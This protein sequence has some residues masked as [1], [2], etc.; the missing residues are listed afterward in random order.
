[1]NNFLSV[2]TI[3]VV[4]TT[5]AGQLAGRYLQ[6]SSNG[7]NRV[8]TVMKNNYYRSANSLPAVSN[9]SGMS[10]SNIEMSDCYNTG[11][12]VGDYYVGGVAGIND[13]TI[14]NCYNAGEVSGYCYVGGV[15]GSNNGTITNCYNTGEASATSSVS[16]VVGYNNGKT[17]NSYYLSD[18]ETDNFD[19]TTAKT[20]DQFASGEVAYLLQGKQTE[21][22]WGQELNKDKFP[23][24]GGEKVY[25]VIPCVDESCYSN[26]ATGNHTVKISPAK[27]ANCTKT[28]LTECK[29]CSRCGKTL[30]ASEIIPAAEHSFENGKCTVCGAEPTYNPNVVYFIPKHWEE[31]DA[32]FAVLAWDAKTG[33]SKFVKLQNENGIYFAEIGE[34]ID[35]VFFRMD[36]E[37]T[38][39]DLDSVWNQ[40][41]VLTIPKGYNCFTVND[42]EYDN[43]NGIW[44]EYLPVKD[45]SVTGDIN[46]TLEEINDNIYTGVV[47][48]QVGTYSFN[49]NDDGTTLGF[50]GTYTDTATIDYSAG[51]TE[52]TKLNA[53]GGKYTFTYNASTKELEIE[54]EPVLVFG[55]A[56][57]NGY[58][59]IID[60]IFVLE[61]IVGK[62]ALN[63]VQSLC[64]DVDSNG[65]ISVLD[66]VLIQKM[67]LGIV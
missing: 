15:A 33:D 19:D 30:V 59:E 23:V 53:T 34:Y 62:I 38:A 36:P 51:T 67:L 64:A 4:N 24:L 47:E 60:V 29:K 41:D 10:Y 45:I 46:L 43:A 20:A 26:T 31:A 37:K 63:E 5:F 16:G 58:I 13:G 22:I 8:D 14:T 39:V 18:S 35:M 57:G 50:N 61:Y 25:Y 7:A 2:G 17:T 42:H 55:D 44:S 54:Y 32:W 66:A 28:G 48:L 6:T 21:Q 49:I 56:N 12:V 65:T 3:T 9:T 40:T 11:E 52:A 27:D 1:M